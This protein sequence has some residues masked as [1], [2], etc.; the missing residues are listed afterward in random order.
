[1]TLFFGFVGAWNILLFWPILLIL[2]YTGWETLEPPRSREVVFFLVINASITF[3]SDL[4]MMLSML[5]TSPLAVTLGLSLTIPLAVFGDIL[6]G[7]QIGGFTLFLGATLVLGGFV[8]VGLAD[9]QEK[10]EEIIDQLLGA[11]ADEDTAANN[12]HGHTARQEPVSEEESAR[13][14][15]LPTHSRSASGRNSPTAGLADPLPSSLA[16]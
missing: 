9:A 16:R 4:L 12:G 10:D 7:T 11:D 6:R 8:A 2:H 5:M 14:P 13:R 15:I 1:M 3:V